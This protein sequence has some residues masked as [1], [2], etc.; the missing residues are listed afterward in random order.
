MVFLCYYDTDQQEIDD[1]ENISVDPTIRSQHELPSNSSLERKIDLALYSRSFI[2]IEE[3]W[4]VHVFVYSLSRIFGKHFT[5]YLVDDVHQVSGTKSREPR[6][7]LGNSGL[8]VGNGKNIR[9]SD[10]LHRFVQ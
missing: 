4:C 6:K 9:I 10:A 3:M 1:V 5:E 7:Y 8:Y 2:T